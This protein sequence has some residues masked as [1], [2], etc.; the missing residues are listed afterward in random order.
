MKGSLV[1]VCQRLGQRM[2]LITR[3]VVKDI[4]SQAHGGGSG[5]FASGLASLG[6]GPGLDSSL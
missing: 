6:R 4:G 1:G 3:S 5:P 2:R